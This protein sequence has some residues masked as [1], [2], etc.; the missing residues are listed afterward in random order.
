MLENDYK[1]Y[2]DAQLYSFNHSD[3]WVARQKSDPGVSFQDKK[4][5]LIIITFSIIGKGLKFWWEVLV[6]YINPSA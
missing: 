4:E 5:T 1:I 3:L 2:S 6:N